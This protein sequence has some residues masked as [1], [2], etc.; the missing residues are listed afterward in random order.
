MNRFVLIFCFLSCGL[1]LQAQVETRAER[2]AQALSEQ[3]PGKLFAQRLALLEQAI[4]ADDPQQLLILQRELML[5]VRESM[6][7][8]TEGAALQALE[9][10]LAA[11]DNFSFHNASGAGRQAKLETLRSVQALIR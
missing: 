11:L 1:G 5:A 2:S 4:Q 3:T 7:R 6:A 9:G 8:Y 10:A